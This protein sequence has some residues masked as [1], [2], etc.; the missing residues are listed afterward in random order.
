M[1]QW[2]KVGVGSVKRRMDY[3]CVLVGGAQPLHDIQLKQLQQQL[4]H[5]LTEHW[6]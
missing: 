5:E 3:N 6:N 2:M 4:N 1:W